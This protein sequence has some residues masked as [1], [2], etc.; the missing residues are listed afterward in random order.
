[1]WSKKYE[2]CVICRTS[3]EKYGGKGMCKSC[4]LKGWNKKNKG[5]TDNYNKKYY[6]DNKEKIKSHVKK[7]KRE[8]KKHYLEYRKNKKN[9]ISEYNRKY[10]KVNRRTII[11]KKTKYSLDRRK[12]DFRFRLKHNVRSLIVIKL[13]NRLLNKNKMS[14]FSFLPYSIDDLIQH[15]EELFKPGMNWG[16][17]G[18]YGWHIDHIKPDCSFKYKSVKDEEFQKCWALNNLQP[19]WARENLK[20]GSNFSY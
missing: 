5:Y 10:Y 9:E 3:G 8:N 13:K 12:T 11:D 20:K 7:Y 1:M 6:K 19:L 14:T 15:L 16:N 2:E 18:F 17:Y 4:Y